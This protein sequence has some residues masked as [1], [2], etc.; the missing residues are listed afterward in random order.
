VGEENSFP[1]EQ[2]K[3]CKE[4]MELIGKLHTLTYQG[5]GLG[6]AARVL[7]ADGGCKAPDAV[8]IAFLQVS[9]Q[10][11]KNTRYVLTD[12]GRQM[13]LV[14]QRQG[15]LPAGPLPPVNP[16]QE[17]MPDEPEGVPW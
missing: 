11:C 9:C 8:P 14:L 15:Y 16:P 3:A 4:A 6:L 17:R 5:S 12:D 10:R 2:C 1:I 7:D 13:V